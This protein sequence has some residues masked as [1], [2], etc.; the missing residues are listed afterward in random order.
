M[1]DTLHLVQH[2]IPM[3]YRP[4][5]DGLRTVAVVAVIVYHAEF[6]IGRGVLLPGGFLGV[7]VFFVISGFLISSIIFREQGSA[8]GF[9]LIHF[10]ERR[11]RRLLPA[12]LVV[13]AGSTIAA[14]HYLLPGQ[15]LQFAKSAIASVFFVSNFFW[16]HTAEQYGTDPALLLPLL[17]TWSL[18]VE[19]QYYIFYPLVLVALLKAPPRVLVVVLSLLLF[20]S[21]VLAHIMSGRDISWSFY[22]LPSR[23][24]ELLAGGLL[25]CWWYFGRR[26]MP[27]ASLANVVSAVAMAGLMFS[28]LAFDLDTHHPGVL[29]LVPVVCTAALITVAHPRAVITR[30][31]SSA[32]FVG[33]GKISYSLYLWH[34][35]VMAFGRLRSADEPDVQDRLEWIVIALVL[36]MLSYFLIEKPFRNRQKIRTPLALGAIAGAGGITLAVAFMVVQ[37]SGVPSRFPQ[38]TA[39]TSGAPA[40]ADVESTG[41]DLKVDKSGRRTIYLLGDSHANQLRHALTDY[42]KPKKIRVERLVE[43]LC[44]YLPELQL[45]RKSNLEDTRCNIEFQRKRR[46]HLL[47]SKPGVVIVASRLAKLT[48]EETFDNREGGNIGKSRVFVQNAARDLRTRRERQA[49]IK[50]QHSDGLLELAEYGH[51]VIVIYPVPETGWHVVQEAQRRMEKSGLS[52]PQMLKQTPL[53]TSYDVYRERNRVGFEIFDALDH[54]RISRVYPHEMLC[55][56]RVP[57]RCVQH[58]DNTLFYNDAS[59]LSQTAILKLMAELVRTMNA[60][61]E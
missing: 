43:S 12:L 46:A 47:A 29:T 37:T 38:L 60:K 22:L 14:W 31:L 28:F 16:H 30:V 9:S 44:A 39:S 23:L 11:A 13:I 21:L 26:V 56:T 8:E 42:A 25:A 58:D 34:Y 19:E 10:Y 61:Q 48:E 50:R 18:A 49:A 2:E 35:P 17:H 57:G 59:H 3:N 54:P 53:N 6:V 33:I 5:I 1:A 51:H 45:S 24:W 55:N 27:G 40:A 15:M 41:S 4:D 52:L 20:A 32:L 7:D 36:S